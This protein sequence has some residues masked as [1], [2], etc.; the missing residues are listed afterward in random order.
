MNDY[1]NKLVCDAANK[2]FDSCVGK[3]L[4]SRTSSPAPLLSH[5]MIAVVS[6]LL[7]KWWERHWI[8]NLAVAYRVA[9]SA[10]E[11][12]VADDEPE[13]RPAS[14]MGAELTDGSVSDASNGRSSEHL[15]ANGTYSKDRVGIAAVPTLPALPTLPATPQRRRRKQPPCNQI[16]ETAGQS[17]ENTKTIGTKQVT[18]DNAAA[19]LDM[20]AVSLEWCQAL[21]GIHVSEQWYRMYD[22]VLDEVLLSEE[23]VMGWHHIFDRAYQHLHTA[24]AALQISCHTVLWLRTR[25]CFSH[26]QV[27]G[28]NVGIINSSQTVTV[29]SCTAVAIT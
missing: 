20:S 5:E 1:I 28:A 8:R 23:R 15:N 24:R 26:W 21:A 25:A 19:V 3:L 16:T 4:Q 10:K 12:I 9:R 11:V 17:K 18:K 13:S 2:E 7:N 27:E 14:S 6:S 22:L 29:H